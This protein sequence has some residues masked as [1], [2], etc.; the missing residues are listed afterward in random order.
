MGP[1]IGFIALLI[2][3]AAA[4]G[5]LFTKLWGQVLGIIMAVIYFLLAIISLLPSLLLR[6]FGIRNPL[7]FSFNIV[8]VLLAIAVIVLAAIAGRRTRSLVP[9]TPPAGTAS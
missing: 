5:M 3:L 2:S 9:A 8:Q 1:I 6:S 7:S 4:L